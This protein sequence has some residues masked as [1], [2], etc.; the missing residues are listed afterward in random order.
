M[1]VPLDRSARF[2]L[3]VPLFFKIGD[4]QQAGHTVNVSQSGLLA[5]FD[6]PLEIW[7]VGEISLTVGEYYL[8][9][10]ARVAR[11]EGDDHG[12]SFII[13]NDNDRVAIRILNDFAISVAT[14]VPMAHVNL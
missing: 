14:G 8:E 5:H 13:E 12:L 2:K 9:I 3:D 7:E 11:A 1:N 6:T 4:T 10:E